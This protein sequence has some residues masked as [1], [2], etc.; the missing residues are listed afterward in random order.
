MSVGI[1]PSSP[2]SAQEVT[3]MV[4]V[5]DAGTGIATV[6]LYVDRSLAQTWTTSGAHSFEGGPYTEGEHTYYVEAVDNAGNTARSPTTG[7][8]TL[9][10][11]APPPPFPWESVIGIIVMVVVISV[12]LILLL[13]RRKTGSS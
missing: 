2:H 4:A 10:V 3:F 6:K 8:T 12:L 13:E 7:T 5:D 11:S 9:T 1:D